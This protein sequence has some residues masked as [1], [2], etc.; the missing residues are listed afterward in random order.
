MHQKVTSTAKLTRRVAEPLRALL[1]RRRRQ[2]LQEL[3]KLQR[4]EQRQFATLTTKLS[5]QWEQMVS[6]FEVDM[7]VSGKCSLAVVVG[8]DGE[9]SVG[10][11]FVSSKVGVPKWGIATLWSVI[12]KLKGRGELTSCLDPFLHLKKLSGF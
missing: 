11:R 5:L 8:G 10:P 1:F 3:R 2:E 4:E 6:R 7:T 9:L 12:L